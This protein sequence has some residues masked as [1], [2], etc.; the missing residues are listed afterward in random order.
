MFNRKKTT[1]DAD[2]QP[3]VEIV[4]KETPYEKAQKY[5]KE[6]DSNST[7]VKGKIRSDREEFSRGIRSVGYY[8]Y[9]DFSLF[10]STIVS[11]FIGG[12]LALFVLSMIIQIWWIQR[13]PRCPKINGN[14]CNAPHGYCSDTGN[15]QCVSMLHSG[16]YCEY[17]ACEDCGEFGEC[18]PWMKKEFIISDCR[19]ENPTPANGYKIS[20]TGWQNPVCKEKLRVL[21]YRLFELGE[22]LSD[23]ERSTIPMC[24]CESPRYGRG[25]RQ[26]ACP[27]NVAQEVC[28]KH[29][30]KSV[31][32]FNNDTISGEGCQC[33]TPFQILDFASE[34]N[35]EMI[36][37]VTANY[38]HLLM[39]QYCA[40][41]VVRTTNSFYLRINMNP[42]EQLSPLKCYCDE[43]TT[44]YGC[45]QDI[46][47]RNPLGEICSG[48][49]APNLGFGL[50]FAAKTKK[51]SKCRA[52]CVDGKKWCPQSESC[53]EDCL[54]E[55]V[56]PP[57]RPF[58]CRNQKCVSNKT[59]MHGGERGYLEQLKPFTFQKNVN[60]S[61]DL[62]AITSPLVGINMVNGNA[63]IFYANFEIYFNAST[64]QNWIPTSPIIREDV[65]FDVAY[66]FTLFGQVSW[67]MYS[68]NWEIASGEY[69]MA[70]RNGD[71]I[72]VNI[73]EEREIIFFNG[74]S[75]V[76]YLTFQ[77]NSQ[78]YA[79]IGSE[80]FVPLSEC[81]FSVDASSR[82][83]FQLLENGN[84]S[85]RFYPNE[86]SITKPTIEET[87]FLKITYVRS[88]NILY[89]V[90]QAMEDE[91]YF[92]VKRLDP[93]DVF[94]F[95]VL[96]DS[97]VGT[98]EYYTQDQLLSTELICT[99][100]LDK[101]VLFGDGYLNQSQFNRKWFADPINPISTTI[102]DYVVYYSFLLDGWER[103]RII[104]QDQ[105]IENI[106]K[107]SLIEVASSIKRSITKKT[108]D[109]LNG[110][111][112]ECPPWLF[113]HKN[114]C[115]WPTFSHTIRT[116]TIVC[117]HD[118]M[119]Q[120]DCLDKRPQCEIYANIFN[121]VRYIY[122]EDGNFTFPTGEVLYA[123]NVTQVFFTLEDNQTEVPVNWTLGEYHP[124]AFSI[125]VTRIASS[126]PDT[127]NNT[128]VSTL[129]WWEPESWDHYVYME[130]QSPDRITLALIHLRSN[131]VELP[132]NTIVIPVFF[133]LYNTSRMWENHTIF[134]SQSSNETSFLLPINKST[135]RIR[136]L[137]LYRFSIYE[138]NAY[139]IQ[140]CPENDTTTLISHIQRN[141]RN[142]TLYKISKGMN[143]SVDCVA[144]QVE[145]ANGICEDEL[146]LRALYNV[147]TKTNYTLLDVAY[148]NTQYFIFLRLAQGVNVSD[149]GQIATITQVNSSLVV[150]N[151]NI[152][153]ALDNFTQW[154]TTHF[155]F[156]KYG[157]FY[158]NYSVVP[159]GHDYMDCGPSTRPFNSTLPGVDCLFSNI[160]MMSFLNY[161]WSIN[162]T[163]RHDYLLSWTCP[164]GNLCADGSCSEV[165]S[166]TW[167]CDGNGCVRPDSK[168]G[169]FKCA[170]AQGRGGLEC[171]FKECK[172][173][174]TDIKIYESTKHDPH[175]DCRV[176]PGLKIKPPA[177]LLLRKN[178]DNREMMRINRNG[179]NRLNSRDIR[180]VHVKPHHGP[181]GIP[182][183]VKRYSKNY[184]VNSKGEREPE[185]IYSDCPYARKDWLGRKMTLNDD[186]EERTS[187]GVVKTWKS[188]YNEV[189]KR[190]ETFPWD[191]ETAYDDFNQRCPNGECVWGVEYCIEDVAC[192][193][194]GKLLVDGTCE[195]NYGWT[196]ALYTESN[197]K[198]KQVSYFFDYRYNLTNPT[199]WDLDNNNWRDYYGEYCKARDCTIQDCSPPM[200]CFTGTP[201]NDFKD[202]HINCP[203]GGCAINSAEC[204]RGINKTPKIPCSGNGIHQKRDYRVDQEEWYCECGFLTVPNA[205]QSTQLTKN[206]FGGPL[207]DQY[208]CSESILKFSRFNE[209]TKKAYQDKFGR[210]LRGV[211]EGYCGAHVG[212]DPDELPL[213]QMCCP[214]SGISKPCNNVPCEIDNKVVCTL[215]EE[216]I[217]SGGVP[218]VYVCNKKGIGRGD[219]TCEC[220]RDETTGKGYTTDYNLGEDNCFKAV[221]CPISALSGT[222]CNAMPRCSDP[223]NWIRGPNH[224]YFNQQAR[225]IL[226]KE[227][228]GF[229]NASLIRELS[230]ITEIENL[231]LQAFTAQARAVQQALADFAVCIYIHDIND[232][233]NTHP[234][235]MVPYP[236]S[237]FTTIQPYQKSYE[238]SYLLPYNA[239][240]DSVLKN[241]IMTSMEFSELILWRDYV[242][243]TNKTS[244]NFS[245]DVKLTAIRIH[246]R[247]LVNDGV[248]TT[249]KFTSPSG[250]A[251][252]L[253]LI[254]DDKWNWTE[255][256][257]T[258]IY[259]DYDYNL[260]GSAYL[261]V[262]SGDDISSN[263]C[264]TFKKDNCPGRFLI[265]SELHIPPRGCDT[266][267]CILVQESIAPDIF[268]RQV[269]F[270]TD[271]N[272]SSVAFDEV[273]FYGYSRGTVKPIP[274]GL[275]KDGV[276]NGTCSAEPDLRYAEQYLGDDKSYFV[277]DGEYNITDARIEAKRR[278]AWVA[279]PI[280]A[281]GLDYQSDSLKEACKNKVG[282]NKFCFI[283]MG[284][285]NFSYGVSNIT[286]FIDP[287]CTAYGCYFGPNNGPDIYGARNSSIY[288]DDVKWGGVMH[289]Q[290]SPLFELRNTIRK[291]QT[292]KKFYPKTVRMRNPDFFSVGY[293]D[294]DIYLAYR[295][296]R[297]TFDNLLD[298]WQPHDFGFQSAFEPLD[299][300]WD[301]DSSDSRSFS[302]RLFPIPYVDHAAYIK[303]VNFR[304]I[305]FQNNKEIWD[306]FDVVDWGSDANRV[307][308]ISACA[309]GNGGPQ[310][311]YCGDYLR[312]AFPYDF[313]GVDL[314]NW[315]EK[316]KITGYYTS[317]WHKFNTL[318]TPLYGNVRSITPSK[319]CYV[320]LT[321]RA[322]NGTISKRKEYIY[323]P[324][325]IVGTLLE[326]QV[327]PVG[328]FRK[329]K[330]RVRSVDPRDRDVT[331]V[332][333]Q[334]TM[335]YIDR[336]WMGM[337]VLTHEAI[338]FTNGDTVGLDWT[339]RAVPTVL[340]TFPGSWVTWSG[341]EYA[342][343]SAEVIKPPSVYI[344][345]D[346][347]SVTNYKLTFD[348]VNSRFVSTESL[349]RPIIDCD[350]CEIRRLSNW[351]FNPHTF[352]QRGGF[353][354]Q[355]TAVKDS[356][357]VIIN[358][359]GGRNIRLDEMKL[360]YST[361]HG[362]VRQSVVHLLP[363]YLVNFTK[364]WC[365]AVSSTT[366]YFHPMPCETKLPVVAQYDFTK[367][368]ALPGR[369]GGKCGHSSRN[370]GYA[371]PG[372]TCID[373]FPL[374][375]ATLFP[376]EH[377]LLAR[378]LDG[379]L[380]L[381]IRNSKYDYD[382][383]I[384]FYKDKPI[385]WALSS[386]WDYW[387]SG[388]VDR[389]G[390]S[391]KGNTYDWLDFSLRKHFGY[392]CGPRVSEKTGLIQSICANDITACDPD[393]VFPPVR[394]ESD[395]PGIYTPSDVNRSNP[396]CG[397]SIRPSS[398]LVRDRFG[399][400]TPG[401][402][403]QFELLETFTNGAI[404]ILTIG[405]YTQVFNTGKTSHMFVFEGNFTITGSIGFECISTCSG[406]VTIWISRLDNTY[407]Y[408]P[409][410]SKVE[411][412]T[413]SITDNSLE[414]EI[415]YFMEQN[416]TYQVLGWDFNL[417]TVAII[418][419]N[420]A[421]ATDDVSMDACA[422]LIPPVLWEAPPAIVSSTPENRCIYNKLD[423]IYYGD[424][425]GRCHCAHMFGGNS[426]D[427]PA[428]KRKVCGGF[429]DFGL[430][431]LGDG[432]DVT[433][434][435]DGCYIANKKAGCKCLDVGKY[436]FTRLL[437][438]SAYDYL[439]VYVPDNIYDEFAYVVL[440]ASTGV[441]NR[442]TVEAEVFLNAKVLISFVNGDELDDY[443]SLSITKPVLMDLTRVG[444]SDISWNTRGIHLDGGG[445]LST[446]GQIPI[447]GV[448]NWTSFLIQ[449]INF[450]NRAFNASDVLHDGS[451]VYYSNISSWSTT[452]SK[453]QYVWIY[454]DNTNNTSSN[455]MLVR[456]K[457]WICSAGLISFNVSNVS[458]IAIYDI[459]TKPV[460]ELL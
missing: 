141:V 133:Q 410:A 147:S 415:D 157:E 306:R 252:P 126:S 205:T 398:Y 459:G 86:S 35:P 385:V 296:Q 340:A 238:S 65:L 10:V 52:N 53:R 397:I 54:V 258:S 360:N 250:L 269:F 59:I 456:G 196:T 406:N 324:Y 307:P 107:A 318:D 144:R 221:D 450:D 151:S 45:E 401:F 282:L 305:T 242:V 68:T 451:F 206:G 210:T 108:H 77:N 181:Y 69:T 20:Y 214:T 102:G 278:G 460:I 313:F 115:V 81:T 191:N 28:S 443:L 198:S 40:D 302:L 227:G 139:T 314:F 416:A 215:S 117:R 2:Q 335:G 137:G 60:I 322:S 334:H 327:F 101:S 6:T 79:W 245:E 386:A 23:Q 183:S 292:E 5:K 203:D 402:S 370:G 330:F 237:S 130:L 121:L 89:P 328:V 85:R 150:I 294:A 232:T 251:C 167:H 281:V 49:G 271:G 113:F 441:I 380:N 448:G 411:L 384:Q 357:I 131:I 34:F 92:L 180:N 104:S 234:R 264:S 125:D 55:D 88:V 288:R 22:D 168:S 1:I 140:R 73:G 287:R 375:N 95:I 348:D 256:Y 93:L 407:T 395:I 388:F 241:D 417:T 209:R 368:V 423:L 408:P 99:K 158:F 175:R 378:L 373:G 303:N 259:E 428:V 218:K 217:P 263:A 159:S 197:T 87:E 57:D 319:P 426:C 148:T 187:R 316:S 78:Q 76:G 156:Y 129:K 371:Q 100:F 84:Y 351:N 270:S 7:I 33:K 369:T 286:Y 26:N 412:A 211:W 434:G 244:F 97:D 9:K 145:S 71:R 163:R 17:S 289:Q 349:G 32:I 178:V 194:N 379:T 381:I 382:K 253:V 445:S 424:D 165:C 224:P 394:L 280:S 337:R 246:A 48:F 414:Y 216:C 248:T 336:P 155:L 301:Y 61:T 179:L 449:G 362:Y 110:G 138:F 239:T 353:P 393:L 153:V 146:H 135:N 199:L 442:T 267:C 374:A 228:K 376:F 290:W 164:F 311:G 343:S 273:Q 98:L 326:L 36:S 413:L 74:T 3:G 43:L 223:T 437:F 37:Y 149:V 365:G 400:L 432:S 169:F 29:G 127:V 347:I 272:M 396:I 419:L 83:E 341:V 247:G 257:C 358:W 404:Q 261:D 298:F 24:M 172:P 230:D 274:D 377:F 128:K 240:N 277:L 8:V 225:I 321:I 383:A 436:F 299:Y 430:M 64:S 361:W 116:D 63:T 284:D 70:R 132:N 143:Y 339:S 446:L 399:G 291:L 366:G 420:N 392:D 333:K 66:R 444:R 266:E 18:W 447:L 262:C 345:P 75:D 41:E 265:T 458:E 39:R 30:N 124:R 425:I 355:A 72:R 427:C 204:S 122:R 297:T 120:L 106:K 433:A 136:L 91:P 184:F 453:I 308:F 429:G 207:C 161:T 67:F 455:C 190:N 96:W 300:I 310:F 13:K 201:A 352:N 231:K 220:N 111:L 152:N 31:D 226:T 403:E 418:T 315:L 452:T 123:N 19:W 331:D 103:G 173:P 50:E 356:G 439:K 222:P 47:P 177:S 193:G 134:A 154:N 14:V 200:G 344:G 323:G 421:I 260:L 304:K 170:C 162:V 212:P 105:E 276:V 235:G 56:C 387:Y 80:E 182:L 186:V 249:I 254:A 25:C 15:C 454:A 354:K 11:R 422:R 208:T 160:T 293:I 171:Q 195:C 188:H 16:Q 4:K 236:T 46:C 317:K 202:A 219:G 329:T 51:H 435:V 142:D 189:L 438:N 185:L 21:R 58:R 332:R 82:C 255:Q 359:Y 90:S 243:I 431:Q 62:I 279:A 363:D 364:D 283:E 233:N 213:W 295:Y 409:T 275:F 457:Q 309:A 338:R 38:E 94:D 389:S 285:W 367:Y 229:S 166:G 268:I 350:E 390:Y 346:L 27:Q 372:A 174:V 325:N 112:V 119:T 342:L 440:N 391:L 42:N 109:K 12:M 44:G 312:D 192:N 320:V 114:R 405:L 118:D 176:D